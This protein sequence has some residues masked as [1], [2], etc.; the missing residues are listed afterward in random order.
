M[1]DIL[2]TLL[3]F[4]LLFVAAVMLYGCSRFFRRVIR[5][6]FCKLRQLLFGRVT[7]PDPL[8]DYMNRAAKLQTKKPTQ[9]T[10]N[11]LPYVRA[12]NERKPPKAVRFCL[13]P[14]HVDKENEPQN[15]NPRRT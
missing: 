13:P 12:A 2:T 8:K 1:F 10:P 5:P 15:K 9:N 7:R 11:K 4:F 3:A 14:G 6:S